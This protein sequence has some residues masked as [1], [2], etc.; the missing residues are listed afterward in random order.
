M[1]LESCHFL[2]EVQNE[3]ISLLIMVLKSELYTA[4]SKL[5]NEKAELEISN[6]ETEQTILFI[7]E[8]VPYLRVMVILSSRKRKED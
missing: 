3:E 2:L 4:Y 8:R 1:E 5:F 7:R 6:K